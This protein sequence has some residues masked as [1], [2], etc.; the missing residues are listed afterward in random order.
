M[1]SW[2]A[3]PEYSDFNRGAPQ[4]FQVTL[5]TDGRIALAWTSGVPTSAVV[6]IAPGYA[7]G[8]TNLVSFNDAS[9][10]YSAAIVERFGNTQEIDIVLAAQ[11]FY[12]THDDAYD[13][14]VF[15]NAG[16]PTRHS[17]HERRAGV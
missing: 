15:Y 6:G 14:L 11:R 1:V 12:Q 17:R 2:V 3:V 13:Y 10:E 7:R 4:T 8:A 5:Y 9:A 16:F